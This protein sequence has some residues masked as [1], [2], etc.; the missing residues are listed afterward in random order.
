MSGVGSGQFVDNVSVKSVIVVVVVVVVVVVASTFKL[1]CHYYVRCR[2]QSVRRQRL[3]EV[4][5]TFICLYRSLVDAG[6]Y[7]NASASASAPDLAAVAGGVLSGL[8]D[9]LAE[10]V[11]F[12]SARTSFL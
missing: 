5:S 4:R 10:K 3:S 6:C 9:N 2:Q 1:I 8:F 11:G 12:R 7:G